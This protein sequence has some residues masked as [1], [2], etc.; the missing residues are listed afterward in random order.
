MRKSK[1]VERG[2]AFLADERLGEL[3]LP[4][5][6]RLVEG[7]IGE[8]EAAGRGTQDQWYTLRWGLRFYDR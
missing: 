3:V 7:V 5:Q 4:R 8:I 1:L 6:Q 2:K